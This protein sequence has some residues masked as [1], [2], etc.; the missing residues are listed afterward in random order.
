[1]LRI[2]L[3]TLLLAPLCSAGADTSLSREVDRYLE[4]TSI[5][6]RPE[7]N[8][9][10]AFRSDDDAFGF[11]L[12]GRVHW[13]TYWRTS[14]APG[15]ESIPGM[16]DNGTF[17]R[18]ARL[19]VQGHVYRYVFFDINVEFAPTPLV[20]R[21]VNIGITDL[22]KI[23]IQ[24]GQSKE[25]FTLEFMTSS[26]YT[27]FLERSSPVS[28][29]APKFNLGIKVQRL[30]AEERLFWILGVFSN[31]TDDEES[32]FI[33]GTAITTRVAG[34]LF[35]DKESGRRVHLGLGFSYRTSRD[36][37]VQFRARPGIGDGP[38]LVDTGEFRIDSAILAGGEV[39]YLWKSFTFQAELIGVWT[40][41]VGGDLDHSFWGVY[42]QIA[43]IVTGE[44]RPYRSGNYSLGRVLPK[45]NF[46]DGSGNYGALEIAFRW[47]LID[48]NSKSVRGGEMMTWTLGANWYWNRNTRLMF[49]LILADERV[50]GQLWTFVVRA[51]FDF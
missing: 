25:P 7:F 21:G 39:A 33:S 13:D 10:L 14:S 46:H 28:A 1:V 16:T 47:D 23:R 49:N 37:T 41:G 50:L 51:Q 36:G 4:E 32:P 3:A 24:L 15:I 8:K 45:R 2:A 20:F 11:E 43:Y 17:F 30:F 31:D 29:F 26:N 38:Y 34:T 40:N 44:R 35:H 22:A 27:M 9:G 42:A 19:G 6:M 5:E 12:T 48:L 18:R